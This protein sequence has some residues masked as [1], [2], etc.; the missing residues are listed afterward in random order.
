[1]RQCF[2]HPPCSQEA[3]PCPSISGTSYLFLMLCSLQRSNWPKCQV[4]KGNPCIRCV[5][6]AW[7]TVS[8][9]DICPFHRCGTQESP[10][11]ESQDSSILGWEMRK[12]ATCWTTGPWMPR[13]ERQVIFWFWNWLQ[14]LLTPPLTFTPHELVIS[15]SSCRGRNQCPQ[16]G[17]GPPKVRVSDGEALEPIGVYA[18]LCSFHWMGPAPTHSYKHLKP[19]AKPGSRTPA[20]SFL[21]STHT[22][23]NHPMRFKLTAQS[24]NGTSIYQS[25][26]LHQ[27]FLVSLI[28]VPP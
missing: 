22:S 27:E 6:W 25:F 19:T 7:R 20:C 26:C 18:R 13:G 9:I 24:R 16:K 15:T 21:H 4:P 3:A 11:T 23:I 8:F 12:S 2:S 5:F 10:S 28:G 14:T 1:M 17:C